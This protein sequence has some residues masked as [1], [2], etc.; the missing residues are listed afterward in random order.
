M[1]ASTIRLISDKEVKQKTG[2]G[3]SARYDRIKQGT[4]PQPVRISSRC[5]RWYEHEIDAWIASLPRGV[6]PPVSVSATS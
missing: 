4:F 5:V 6:N 3:H 2:L 1:T